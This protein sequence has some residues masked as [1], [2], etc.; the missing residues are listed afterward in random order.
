MGITKRVTF[1]M[2]TALSLVFFSCGEKGEDGNTTSLVEPVEE[3]Y[4]VIVD[5]PDEDYVSRTIEQKESYPIFSNLIMERGYRIY[6][7]DAAHF[8]VYDNETGEISRVTMIPCVLPDD[9]S[10]VGVIYYL[11]N[12]NRYIVTSAEFFES[13]DYNVPHSLD[14]EALQRMIDS[15]GSKEEAIRLTIMQTEAASYWKCVA[16]R[17]SA[18]CLGCGVHCFFA[19]PGWAHCTVACCTGAAIVAMV[20]C[21]FSVMGW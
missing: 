2:L 4:E 10:R 6:P 18:G 14:T 1:G 17:F 9:K 20:S 12:D 19:G 11:E 15:A 8:S 21:L 13:E 3:Q 7:Q 16:N 5:Y